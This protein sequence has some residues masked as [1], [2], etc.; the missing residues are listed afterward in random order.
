MGKTYKNY[1]SVRD[2]EISSKRSGKS[3]KHASGRKT[4]GM[5]TLNN[6]VEQDYDFESYDPFDDEIEMTDDITVQHN[7]N[8]NDTP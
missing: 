1:S 3:A 2:D 7:I 4:G 5:R 6:Y 8:T